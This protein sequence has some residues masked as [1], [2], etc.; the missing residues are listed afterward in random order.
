MEDLR[1]DRHEEADTRMIAHM[2]H[3]QGKFD[4]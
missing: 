2:A 1:C 4:Y 3:V